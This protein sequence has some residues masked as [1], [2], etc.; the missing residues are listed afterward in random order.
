MDRLLVLCIAVMMLTIN[1]DA[2]ERRLLNASIANKARRAHAA[3]HALRVKQSSR[4]RQRQTAAHQSQVA[5]PVSAEETAP[6]ANGRYLPH[7]A[8]GQGWKT[9]LDVINTCPNPIAYEVDFF[10]SSGE[11]YRFEFSDGERYSGITSGEELLG[12]SIDS[13]QLVDTGRELLQGAGVVTED[14]GGCVAIETFYI[15]TREDEDGDEYSMF[16]TVPLQL[17]EG[18]GSVLTFFNGGSCDTAMALT[19]TGGTV[20]IDAFGPEGQSFGSTALDNLYHEA[21]SIGQ[22]FPRTRGQLGMLRISGGAAVLG[23]DFCSGDLMQFRLAHL[24]PMAAGSVQPPRDDPPGEGSSVV[25][26]F[27]VKLTD[28]TS[29]GWAGLPT[30]T[31]GIKLTLN[32]SMAES[33][34][35]TA[36]VKFNDSDGFLVESMTFFPDITHYPNRL[37]LDCWTGTDCE[38]DLPVEA[39]Q[40]R[41]FQGNIMLFVKEAVKVD[42]EQT[43]V[44]V[45]ESPRGPFAP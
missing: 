4:I 25:K 10:D 35:Y 30:Y 16:A 28:T 34:I 18:R 6:P 38:W 24:G 45:S 22:R 42:L 14:G 19:G 8:Q 3:A 27:T 11:P 43:T 26:L 44:T 2:N 40:S 33:Q 7:L 41:E 12:N 36:K 1:A 5:A 15:Q 13:F 39:G 23:M 9:F 32:N 21:F 17:M 37:T 29:K 20:W 31:Y